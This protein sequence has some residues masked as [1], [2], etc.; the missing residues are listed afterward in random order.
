MKEKEKEI[1]SV[2]EEKSP[3][4]QWQDMKYDEQKT[5]SER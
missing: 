2:P 1:L 5:V 4:R 3:E